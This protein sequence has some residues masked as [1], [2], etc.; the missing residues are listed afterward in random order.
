[1]KFLDGLSSSDVCEYS[2]FLIGILVTGFVLYTWILQPSHWSGSD[3]EYTKCL[4][5]VLRQGNILDAN[6]MCAD[7]K[8]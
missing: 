6:T 3:T 7:R 2:L 5:L 1:M 4:E 8:K